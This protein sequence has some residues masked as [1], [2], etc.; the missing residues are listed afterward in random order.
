MPNGE[1]KPGSAA[2][3]QVQSMKRALAT[4]AIDQVRSLRKTLPWLVDGESDLQDELFYELRK[5]S[6][7][8]E[9]KYQCLQRICW[10]GVSW[11]VRSI[12][13]PC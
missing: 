4:Q 10:L 2:F 13:S 7:E 6:R 9:S 12:C 3:E 1:N 5:L 11:K 8:T